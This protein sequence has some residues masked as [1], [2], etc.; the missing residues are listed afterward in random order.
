MEFGELMLAAI[1][2]VVLYSHH[3]SH[4][5]GGSACLSHLTPRVILW[6]EGA[7][8]LNYV[9]FLEYATERIFLRRVGGGYSFVHRLVQEHFAKHEQELIAR[10]CGPSAHRGQHSHSRGQ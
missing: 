5:I 8:P 1:A 7:M 2:C 4:H 6:R 3:N 9:R 10:V